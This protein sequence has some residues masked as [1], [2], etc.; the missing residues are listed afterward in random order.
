MNI[1]VKRDWPEMMEKNLVVEKKIFKRN[2]N[3]NVKK[4]LTKTL[5]K[6]FENLNHFFA[7]L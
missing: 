4:V 1:Y 5:P 7:D 2:F 6:I 3:F